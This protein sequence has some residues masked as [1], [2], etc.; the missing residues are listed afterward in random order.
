MKRTVLASAFALAL[1]GF[2]ASPAFADATSTTTEAV[3]PIPESPSAE[4]TGTGTSTAL[5]PEQLGGP[6]SNGFAEAAPPQDSTDPSDVLPDHGSAD[7]GPSDNSSSDNPS[8]A[9][10]KPGAG[11]STAPSRPGYLPGPT[12]QASS[13]RTNNTGRTASERGT[14][15]ASAGDVSTDAPKDG[16]SAGKTNAAARAEGSTATDSAND[17]GSIETNANGTGTKSA[18]TTTPSDGIDDASTA[19][20]DDTDKSESADSGTDSDTPAQ[21]DASVTVSADEVTES[22]LYFEGVTVTVSDLEPGDRVT[23]SLDDEVTVARSSTVEF[24]YLPEDFVEPGVVDFTVTVARKGAVDQ[25]IGS[26]FTLVSDLDVTEG[27]LTLSASRMSVS[28]FAAKGIDFTAEPFAQGGPILGFAFSD[29]SESALYFDGGLTADSSGRVS[30]TLTADSD[31]EPVPGDH[32]L[33]IISAD[34][35]AW[36]DFTLTEDVVPN[37][38]TNPTESTNSGAE[39][40]GSKNTALPQAQNESTSR[41]RTSAHWSRAGSAWSESEE[42]ASESASLPRTGAELGSLGLGAALL[43]AGAAMVAITV[44]RR[45]EPK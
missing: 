27:T 9:G 1:F 43:L 39:T 36:A 33:F 11:D 24:M 37:E 42:E 22:D 23:N 8:S 29:D 10:E 38:S 6:S 7:H 28:D 14:T 20:T 2:G 4:S 44:H 15:S 25:A 35:E 12:T 19:G 16:S 34:A 32:H 31:A 13:D 41:E 30:G 5:V 40:T 21:I 3:A 26:E 18:D 17:A 45:S